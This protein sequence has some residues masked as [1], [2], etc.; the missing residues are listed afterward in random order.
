MIANAVVPERFS[1]A[2]AL[3]L[4]GA[5]MRAPLDSPMRDALSVAIDEDTLARAQRVQL[6]RLGEATVTLPLISSHISAEELERL[7]DGL[8]VLA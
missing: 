3:A 4:R 5:R 6:E 2:D 8:S 1:A 7:A